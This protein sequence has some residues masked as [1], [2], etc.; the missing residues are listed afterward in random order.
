M[1]MKTNRKILAIKMI[2]TT[3]L[4]KI[5]M[6]Y[7]NKEEFK[8]TDIFLLDKIETKIEMIGGS[9]VDMKLRDK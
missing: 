9:L 7:V 5:F 3:F 8:A 4:S 1:K 6:I 2:S